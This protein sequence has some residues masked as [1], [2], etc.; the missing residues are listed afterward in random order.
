MA[1]RHALIIRLRLILTRIWISILVTL[2]E[3]FIFLRVLAVLHVFLGQIFGVLR[4]D[5]LTIRRLIVGVWRTILCGLIILRISTIDVL[6]YIIL[7]YTSSIIGVIILIRTRIIG[8][9][10]RIIGVLNG[11]VIIGWRVV[12][13]RRTLILGLTI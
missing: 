13:V 3:G 4:W 2:S 1:E 6:A 5:T 7:L 12:R 11:L 8:V 10:L 9:V